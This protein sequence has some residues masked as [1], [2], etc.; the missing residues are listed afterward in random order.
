MCG[1]LG[2][3]SNKG[4]QVDKQKV[5]TLLQHRGPD[6]N[7]GY[8]SPNGK[9]YFHHYRLSI[10]DLSELANQPMVSSCGKYVIIFNGEIYNYLELR[11]KL[12]HFNWKTSGDTEL[13]VELYAHYGEQIIAW[14][15]G[16]FAFAIYNVETE[17]LVLARD[18]IGIKPIYYYWDEN[19]F[20]F[21]SEIKAIKSI[22]PQKPEVDLTTI[23]YFL[24]LGFIP[25]PHS[26]YKNIYKFPSASFCKISLRT[27][28]KDKKFI[29]TNSYWK[30]YKRL[31][32]K[33]F[34]NYKKA[35]SQLEEL[36]I[37]S[38]DK[39]LISDVPIGTF[40]SGGID[41]SLVTAI[42]GKIKK[43]TINTFSIG[44]NEKEYDESYYAENVAYFL[45]TNHHTIKV[46]QQDV[47]ELLPN[48]IKVYDEPF[49]DTSA[50]PTMLI[51]KF[52]RQHVKVVLTG[53]GGDELFLGYGNYIWANRLNNPFVKALH[54]P[55]Y[56]LTK[57]GNNRI[58]RGGL[59]LDYG[60]NSTNIQSH[61]YSQENYS[62]A[63][64]ELKNYLKISTGNFASVRQS[65]KI[66]R[67]LSH[68]EQQSLWDINFYLKDDL[69]IKVDRA[70][71]LYSLEARVPLLDYRIV[72]FA[73]N[74]QQ[75]FKLRNGIS[76]YIL[77]DVLYKF[78]PKEYFNRPKK[79]FAIPL[80]LWLQK[81]WRFLIDKYLSKQC[82]EQYGIFNVEKVEELKQR[83][84]KGE[85][86]L[87]NRIWVIIVLHWWLEENA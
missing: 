24:H 17:E 60:K 78:I 69:L 7:G 27:Y 80:Q 71:M 51:S 57:F 43:D 52:A 15:N 10:L 8:T 22:L 48:I 3:F 54:Q 33:R 45:K 18:Q 16:M 39:Q 29:E 5:S 56:Q 49:S 21:S 32:E 36:I 73:A 62:F 44:Y 50:Y 20:I 85:D 53:E 67:N 65:A 47:H 1:I 41:S 61:I 9:L 81:E 19:T 25:E 11:Q 26:I 28:K 70:S 77:K 38:I 23:P 12:L 42:A 37:D 79:G 83:F 66:K 40:L 55:F 31:K 76:K 82:I 58:K 84:F 34:S 68:I 63:Q 59:L 35:V 72:E 13:I 75:D 6:T 14:L 86:F 74:L 46:T 4:V 64:K 87:Y 30:L 2:I